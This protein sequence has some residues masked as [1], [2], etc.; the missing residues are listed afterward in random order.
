MALTAPIPPFVYKKKNQR[1]MIFFVPLFCL[2]FIFLY[3]PLDLTNTEFITALNLPL[4]RET[5]WH[6]LII[7]LVL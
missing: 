1:L 3:Q 7:L 6:L 5:T 2:A 4:R